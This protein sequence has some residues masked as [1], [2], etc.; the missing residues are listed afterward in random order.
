MN[1]LLDSSLFEEGNPGSPTTPVSTP[2]LL[3]AQSALWVVDTLLRTAT[4]FS[5]PTPRSSPVDPDLV[6]KAVKLLQWDHGSLCLRK[7]QASIAPRT[8]QARKP[9]AG[10]LIMRLNSKAMVDGVFRRP[11]RADGSRPEILVRSSVK[12]L[13]KV[14]R[15]EVSDDAP[16]FKKSRLKSQELGA[17]L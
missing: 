17:F 3:R 2:T 8:C 5:E 1:R 11:N 7:H 12:P 15:T 13:Y 16:Q 10:P 14:L 6:S 4:E 9:P